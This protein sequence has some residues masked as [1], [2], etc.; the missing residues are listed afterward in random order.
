MSHFTGKLNQSGK[1]NYKIQMSK[2]YIYEGL[3]NPL[4]PEAC[5]IKLSSMSLCRNS[6]YFLEDNFKIV[7]FETKSDKSLFGELKSHLNNNNTMSNKSLHCHCTYDPISF[8]LFCHNMQNPF[9]KT[10]SILLEW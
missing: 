5:I 2:K 6:S 8:M 10:Q 1:Y 4:C 3:W 9:G 7:L